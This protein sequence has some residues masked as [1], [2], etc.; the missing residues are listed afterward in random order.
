LPAFGPIKREELLIKLQR[1]G[2]EGP[3]TGA[4]YEFLVK[5]EL[6][7][8]LLNPLTGEIGK[9]VFARILRHVALSCGEW[10]KL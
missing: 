3:F 8:V 4:K 7:L 10:E 9:E 5:G 1:A 6:R 2:L